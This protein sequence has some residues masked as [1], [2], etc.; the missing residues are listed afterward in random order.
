MA[1]VWAE[2]SHSSSKNGLWSQSKPYHQSW[3]LSTKAL[4]SPFIINIGPFIPLGAI[5]LGPASMIV[6]AS[7]LALERVLSSE[8]SMGLGEMQ[9]VVFNPNRW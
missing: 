2:V 3:G 1:Q 9:G 4:F 6:V 5:S 7:M 8:H